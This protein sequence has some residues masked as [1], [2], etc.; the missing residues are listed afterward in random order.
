MWQCD[1]YNN[2]FLSYGP[3]RLETLL[4]KN[5]VKTMKRAKGWEKIFVDHIANEV[6][7]SGTHKE[8][9]VTQQ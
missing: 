7:I 6:L 9:S 4:C 1:G 3:S 8:L 5:P 2:L